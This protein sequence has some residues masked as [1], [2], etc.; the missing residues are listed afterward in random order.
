MAQ[1]ERF[2]SISIGPGLS[3]DKRAKDITIKI[4]NILQEKDSKSIQIILDA[5][6]LN[7]LS[8]INEWWKKIPSECILTPHFGEMSR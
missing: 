3:L 2:N 6:A 5:D 4:L 1:N 8:N 7:H